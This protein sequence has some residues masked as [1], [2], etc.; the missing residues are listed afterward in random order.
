MQCP[1]CGNY[2]TRPSTLRGDVPITRFCTRCYKTFSVPPT[3]G[4]EK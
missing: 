4:E 1:N 3:G 2:Y